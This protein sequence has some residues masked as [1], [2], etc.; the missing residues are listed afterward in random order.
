MAAPRGPMPDWRVSDEILL[1]H[2]WTPGHLTLP[3]AP[4]PGP[5]IVV[6]HDWWGLDGQTRSVVD[7]LAA[8]GHAAFAPDL[9]RGRLAEHAD[10]AAR[11]ARHLESAD[12]TSEL[13]D[14]VDLVQALPG[15]PWPDGSS[16][17]NASA[18]AGLPS[19][20]LPGASPSPGPVAVIGLGLG[21]AL[22]LY[23]ASRHPDVRVVVCYD[24]FP[25]PEATFEW[26]GAPA[27]VLGH[28]CQ[29]EFQR[30]GQVQAALR[31]CEVE[32]SVFLYP[33][34]PHGFFDATRPDNHDRAAAELSWR[35]TIRFLGERSGTASAPGR[36]TA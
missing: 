30:A 27:A 28:A 12:L 14:A 15:S 2:G 35:R 11:L 18:G 19:A 17:A 26:A 5:R 36:F 24:G 8:E 32:A 16:S 10:E 21:G 6:L 33:S 7:R 22:A 3:A 29:P 31:R 20:G 25:P 1:R 4:G 23:L 9:Y 34:A 13:V